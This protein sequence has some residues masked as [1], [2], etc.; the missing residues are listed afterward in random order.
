[1]KCNFQHALAEVLMD[2]LESISIKHEQLEMTDFL[3]LFIFTI[4]FEKDQFKFHPDEA[5]LPSV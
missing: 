2:T 5:K 4:E 1:M 3:G